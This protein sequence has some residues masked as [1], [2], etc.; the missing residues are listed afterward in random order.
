MREKIDYSITG[1]YP[2]VNVLIWGNTEKRKNTIYGTIVT[3]IPD[4]NSR[5]GL[6]YK[7]KGGAGM[8]VIRQDDKQEH[9]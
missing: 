2:P 5:D 1:G 7:V 4:A 6:I 9:L 3:N 8:G